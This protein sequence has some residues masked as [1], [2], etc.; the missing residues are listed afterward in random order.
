M[1]AWLWLI[2]E[3][4]W[5]DRTRVIQGKEIMLERGQLAVSQRF[6]AGAWNW[7]HKAVREYLGR[8][9]RFGM[10]KTAC[11]RIEFKRGT[12]E[13]TAK[14]TG[15]TVLTICNYETYQD[16]SHFKGTGEGTA[17]GTRGAQQGH[18]R[19]TNE[20]KDTLIPSK[21]S[22]SI[23]PKG[24]EEEAKAPLQ[25]SPTVVGALR[26]HVGQTYADEL[27][28]KYLAN[29]YAKRAKVIDRA[30]QGWLRKT[31]GIVISLAGSA[32]PSR[33]EVL[34]LCPTDASGRPNTKLPKVV[35]NGHD[36]KAAARR[37]TR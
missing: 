28:A 29:P 35:S 20:N 7:G 8:L 33:A 25:L 21:N 11:V 37:T 9:V 24:S 13:G 19:G 36:W 14:G 15:I 12:G 3:A 5:R 30:F 16:A 23:D 27:A 2:K 22:S 1:L 18:S 26:Q 6:M 32:M 10:V 34:D 31:Y 4:S 17:K